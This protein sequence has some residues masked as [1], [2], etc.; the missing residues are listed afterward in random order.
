MFGLFIN[1]RLCSQ[2]EFPCFLRTTK[3]LCLKQRYKYEL[4]LHVSL[5]LI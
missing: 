3:L 5:R 4:H 2:V 1:A